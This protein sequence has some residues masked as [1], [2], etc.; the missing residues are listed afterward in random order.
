MSSGTD[1]INAGWSVL[2][3]HHAIQASHFPA[4]A[5]N[6]NVL[7]VLDNGQPE[8]PANLAYRLAG[9]SRVITATRSGI[10]FERNDLI[11]LGTQGYRVLEI[12][13]VSEQAVRLALGTQ[14]V[15][16]KQ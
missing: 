8:S 5:G 16:G 9:I 15:A 6:I 11:V 10:N 3:D 4:S 7:K 2:L 14:V 12:L 1:L 13:A